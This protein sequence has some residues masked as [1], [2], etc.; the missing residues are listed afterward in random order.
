MVRD[1]KRGHTS[2]EKKRVPHFWK[3]KGPLHLERERRAPNN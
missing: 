3:L 2:G 1:R